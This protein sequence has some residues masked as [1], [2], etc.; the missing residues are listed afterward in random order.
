MTKDPF[1][2][3]KYDLL[4][5]RPDL[6][7]PENRPLPINMNRAL[8]NPGEPFPTQ[9]DGTSWDFFYS[10][11]TAF[12]KD[13]S[14]KEFSDIAF[15]SLRRPEDSLSVFALLVNAD[16]K[17]QS[18]MQKPHNGTI[19]F[20]AAA[21]G[22]AVE[23]IFHVPV[24]LQDPAP[25]LDPPEPS[26]S[27]TRY[28][29]TAAPGPF[30]EPR[31]GGGDPQGERSLDSGPRDGGTVEEDHPNL[32]IDFDEPG[33]GSEEDDEPDTINGLTFPE[34]RTVL[35]RVSDGKISDRERA[36]AAML[37]LGMAG[38]GL[39]S[40]LS[41]LPISDSEHQAVLGVHRPSLR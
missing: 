16:S 10:N 25:S 15:K 19:E 21:T 11:S 28:L 27:S 36:E 24:Q 29:D 38:G 6:F 1:V 37:M 14:R 22:A 7:L 20:Y 12:L 3:R 5:L 35:Q 39:S 40:L 31:E 2:F 18:A 4:V 32:G 17:L 9:L 8:R 13:S 30:T 23:A 26:P 41:A 33:Y 34:M